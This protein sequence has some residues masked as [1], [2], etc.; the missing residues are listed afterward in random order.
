MFDN[1]AVLVKL[2]LITRFGEGGSRWTFVST[3]AQQN[4]SIPGAVANALQT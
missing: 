2:L 3:V 4:I 1:E